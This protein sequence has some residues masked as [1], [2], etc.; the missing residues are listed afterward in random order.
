MHGHP[1][2]GFD[3][4]IEHPNPIVFKQH[5]VRLRR[6]FHD[7]SLRPFPSH[8]ITTSHSEG[9]P[10]AYDPNCSCC[11]S[12]APNCFAC[13]T[14]FCALGERFYSLIV[15]FRRSLIDR[16]LCYGDFSPTDLRPP[17]CKGLA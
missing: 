8:P 10:Y 1:F 16:V 3:T 15:E 14:S 9:L 6:N 13:P 12:C 2:T 11:L 5:S 7:V 4:N 17:Q